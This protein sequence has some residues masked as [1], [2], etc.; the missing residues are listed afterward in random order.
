MCTEGS[1]ELHFQ[2]ETYHYKTGDTILVPAIITNFTING[3][4]T[5]LEVTV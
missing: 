3:K 2:S 1:F 4:A 5:L